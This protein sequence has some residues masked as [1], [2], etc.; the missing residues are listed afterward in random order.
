MGNVANNPANL[1]FL[2]EAVSGK[3]VRQVSWLSAVAADVAGYAPSP[4]T[5]AGPRGTCTRFPILSALTRST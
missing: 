4:I 1:T 2:L 5:V 3:R